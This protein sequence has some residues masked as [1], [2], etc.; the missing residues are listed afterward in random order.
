ML[1]LNLLWTTVGRGK[2]VSY[3]KRVPQRSGCCLIF[4]EGGEGETVVRQ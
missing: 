4:I 1:G 3:F 2:R